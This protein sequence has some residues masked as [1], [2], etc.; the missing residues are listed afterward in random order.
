MVARKEKRMR[1]GTN[2][3]QKSKTSV[4]YD[5]TEKSGR[6]KAIEHIKKLCPSAQKITIKKDNRER[7]YI[8]R[9]M[10]PGTRLFVGVGIIEYTLMSEKTDKGGWRK[11][12][13]MYGKCFMDTIKY[14]AKSFSY[15]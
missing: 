9:I 3:I 4:D 2:Y 14:Y 10:K 13:L 5:L 1:H 11:C 8:I 6:E 15:P 12:G 7:R